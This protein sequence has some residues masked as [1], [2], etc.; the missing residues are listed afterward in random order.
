MPDFEYP[1]NNVQ[2]GVKD[3]LIYELKQP[4]GQVRVKA[5]GTVTVELA[6]AE[7]PQDV[8]K[9]LRKILPDGY[10]LRVKE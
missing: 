8:E 9:E 5:D 1:P 7:L 4:I 3:F 2:R 6:G 10:K